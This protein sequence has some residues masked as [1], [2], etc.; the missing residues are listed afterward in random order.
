MAETKREVSYTERLLDRIRT[1]DA[2]DSELWSIAAL[3]ILVL[4]A[5]VVLGV[6]PTVGSWVGGLEVGER[7][8]P[9][10]L[11]GFIA[12]IVLFDVYALEQRRLSRKSRQAL[13]DQLVR[14]ERAEQL[15]LLDPLTET[16]NRRYLEHV[17]VTESSR[18]D[19]TGS[20]LSVM[21]IDLDNFRDVNSRYGHIE[22]D[23]V[24]IR[25]ARL[26]R[27]V[28]RQADTVVRYG[29][30]EFLVVMPDTDPDQAGIA[31]RRLLAGVERTNA[32][33]DGDHP[34]LSLSCGVASCAK[35][36]DIHEVIE[37]ADRAMYEAKTAAGRRRGE[38]PPGRDSSGVPA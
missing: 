23:R 12:L 5:A 25:A 18:S 8:L 20:A 15:S 13:M 24:L 29:G 36:D 34:R 17:L 32:E 30:D 9:K 6:L 37:A 33:L 27:K 31:L 11:I 4:A 14:A 19:R 28:F 10:L 26:L 7:L 21:M 1:V 3:V 16:F 35:G 38:P 2:R 22:G